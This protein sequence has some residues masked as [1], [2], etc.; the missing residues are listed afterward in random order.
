[1]K[2]KSDLP[3]KTCPICQRSFAWRK[4]WKDC[5]QE[6]KYCSERCRRNRKGEAPGRSEDG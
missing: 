2:K 1:M 3:T 6:V 4:K 5:W